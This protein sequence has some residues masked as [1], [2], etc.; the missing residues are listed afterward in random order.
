MEPDYVDIDLVLESAPGQYV[1]AEYHQGARGKP[2]YR[3]VEAV[4]GVNWGIRVRNKSQ[5]RVEIVAS[6]DGRDVQTGEAAKSE[7]RGLVISAGAETI[8]PGWRVDQNNVAKFVFKDDYSYAADSGDGNTANVGLVH[9]DVYKEYVTKRLLGEENTDYGYRLRSASA[10]QS[11]SIGT[12][13]GAQTTSRVGTTTFDRDPTSKAFQT[14]RYDTA[15]NLRLLGFSVEE[16][17][18]LPEDLLKRENA[19]PY[20]ADTQYCRP[21]ADWKG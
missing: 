8:I 13:F 20:P 6:V 19:N 14:F 9:V 4:D 17:P 5:R 1:P 21:P 18:P 11:K 2:G 7:Q 10:P 3:Y 15:E 16:K 12:G